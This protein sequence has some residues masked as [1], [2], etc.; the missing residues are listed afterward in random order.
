MR[1]QLN[2]I[3]EKR[4]LNSQKS[5]HSESQLTIRVR[6]KKNNSE[7]KKECWTKQKTYRDQLIWICYLKNKNVENELKKYFINAS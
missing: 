1:K 7:K 4:L 6:M 3:N 2:D 5:N